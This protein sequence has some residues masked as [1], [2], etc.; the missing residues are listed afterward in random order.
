MPEWVKDKKKW[1]KAAEIVKKQ[2]DKDEKEK[3]FWKLVTGV[4]KNMG[5][6]IKGK[7]KNEGTVLRINTWD[8]EIE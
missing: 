4:Y 5:G 6:E 7:S 8:G 1:E 2:Y 3:D